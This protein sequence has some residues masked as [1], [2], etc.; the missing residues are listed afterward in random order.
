MKFESSAEVN[1]CPEVVWA[2]VKNP[3]EWPLWVP[4]LKKV[5]RLSP[6]PLGVGS[7]LYVTVK[8]IVKVRLH[9]VIT[10]F[11]PE[12]GV[13]MQGKVLCT[14]LTRFYRLEGVGQRT[15]L[16]AGGEASGPL[17]WLVCRSGRKLSEEIV[18][19]LKKRVEEVSI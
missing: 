12:S 3:E 10:K 2:A 11:I 4:S 15:R 14:R 19:A 1:A 13:T 9:M 18:Q 16:M 6:G 17:A 8:A 7:R 5:E